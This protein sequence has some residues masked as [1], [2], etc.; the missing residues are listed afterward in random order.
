MVTDPSKAE[1][2]KGALLGIRGEELRRSYVPS[3]RSSKANAV[4]LRDEA[5]REYEYATR[6][7]E[8]LDGKA[9][10]ALGGALALLAIA[11]SVSGSV[12]LRWAAG[13]TAGVAGILAS[14]TLA[15]D[16]VRA[17]STKVMADKHGTEPS[18]LLLLRMASQYADAAT[19]TIL[20]MKVKVLRLRL[21]LILL[22]IA[23]VALGLR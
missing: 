15:P 23:A 12:S 4:T 1:I 13:L 14:M 8:S 16:R 2:W 20:P 18:A 19:S 21:A 6:A 10:V 5:A 17:V 7:L 9:G 3:L 22:F 11:T